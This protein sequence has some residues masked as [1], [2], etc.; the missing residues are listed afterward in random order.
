M[1]D[2][3]TQIN[4]NLFLLQWE[5]LAATVGDGGEHHKLRTIPLFC[6]ISYVV[7][8]YIKK[9]SKAWKTPTL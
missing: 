2:V 1:A 9:N 5:N 6:S 4:N 3:K 8:Q 7:I